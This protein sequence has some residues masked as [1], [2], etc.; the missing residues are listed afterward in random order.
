MYTKT[1]ITFFVTWQEE[2]PPT[3]PA[4]D[5]QQEAAEILASLAGEAPAANTPSDPSNND[6]LSD[7][8]YSSDC[9]E[10]GWD[11]PIDPECLENSMPGLFGKA[12]DAGE[13]T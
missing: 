4:T 13:A 5:N 7:S 8:E 9:S 1:N 3:L 6:H 11:D 10:P 12:E 2:Y